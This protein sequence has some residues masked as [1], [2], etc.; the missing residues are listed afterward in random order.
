MFN[1][2]FPICYQSTFYGEKLRQVKRWQAELDKRLDLSHLLR[3]QLI[4]LG[5][6]SQV[7]HRKL[8]E[9]ESEINKLQKLIDG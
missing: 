7:L 5:E 6:Q 8:D 9:N 2:Q 3:A 4:A 1:H